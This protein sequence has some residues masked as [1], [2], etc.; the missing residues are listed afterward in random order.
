MDDVS[1][2]DFNDI[3]YE[4]SDENG[5]DISVHSD[6]N[7][8]HDH[9]SNGE[10]VTH[11]K[12][13]RER[14]LADIDSVKGLGMSKQKVKAGQHLGEKS[15]EKTSGAAS[16]HFDFA[17]A[18]TEQLTKKTKPIEADEWREGETFNDDPKHAVEAGK[19]DSIFFD[20]EDKDNDINGG[21]FSSKADKSISVADK[22]ISE[23]EKNGVEK[24]VCYLCMI[25]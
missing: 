24:S 13:K 1:N 18:L 25:V 14:I 8:Q 10:V 20:D 2:N 22:S 21:I 15:L 23:S 4:D 5:N 7:Y 19:D 3:L 6:S 11:K 17:A 9:S 12:K 16:Q